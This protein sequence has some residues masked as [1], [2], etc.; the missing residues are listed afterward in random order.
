MQP[1]H[2]TRCPAPDCT[3]WAGS[4]SRFCSAHTKRPP[5]DA[6]SWTHALLSVEVARQVTAAGD[7]PNLDGE[8]GAIRLSL[9]NVILNVLDPIEQAKLIAQLA[10][11]ATRVA[12]ARRALSGEEAD[13]LTDAFTQILLSMGGD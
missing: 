6:P 11:A 12:K 3:R 9:A 5:L 1:N 10:S 13:S 7:D 2:R 4:D 8:L